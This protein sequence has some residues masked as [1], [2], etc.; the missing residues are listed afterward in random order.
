MSEPIKVNIDKGKL[1]TFDL[2]V[3]GLD[4][5]QLSGKFR[6]L[7][8]EVEYGFPTTI[9]DRQ[10]EVYVP[11]LHE[12]LKKNKREFLKAK[13]E[14]FADSHFFIPWEGKLN[15]IESATV[16]AKVKTS[17]PKVR[18]EVKDQDVKEDLEVIVDEPEEEVTLPQPKKKV[19]EQITLTESKKSEY[20]ELLKNIDEKGIRDYMKR[21]GTKNE[22]VQNLIL[23]QAE[24]LCREPENKFELLKSVIKVMNKIK[25]GG[26]K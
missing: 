15:L 11:C 7:I 12:I 3:Q 20:L 5:S 16:K 2:D 10:V 21:A 4:E 24:G 17:G 6:V 13:L 26:K 23:E 9:S 22:A 1:I 19:S 18:T 25:K 14:I 8:N